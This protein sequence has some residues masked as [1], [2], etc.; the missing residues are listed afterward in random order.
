MSG[1]ECTR[2]VVGICPPCFVALQEWRGTKKLKI[3]H[4][5][6]GYHT[7][8]SRRNLGFE[9]RCWN[10]REQLRFHY[11]NL[12]VFKSGG[13]LKHFFAPVAQWTARST[14]NRKVAS[15]SLA[16]SALG[17]RLDTANKK[18]V[19]FF[20]SRQPVPDIPVV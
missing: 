2:K 18:N 6:G 16:W 10:R 19:N 12:G 15:S 7:C 13:A 5:V 20:A 17:Y 14:S 4:D 1:G 3:R 9:S 11:V 8:F